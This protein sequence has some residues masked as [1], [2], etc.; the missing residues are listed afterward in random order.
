MS[1][2]RSFSATVISRSNSENS[3]P[4]RTPGHTR[5]G[6]SISNALSGAGHPRRSLGS[7]LGNG[8]I[9]NRGSS[10]G[11]VPFTKHGGKG[12]TTVEKFDSDANKENIAPLRLV[13]LT[14]PS[15]KRRQVKRFYSDSFARSASLST[16]EDES[17]RIHVIKLTSLDVEDSDGK[18]KDSNAKRKMKNT[19]TSLTPTP[20]ATK[21]TTTTLEMNGKVLLRVE[22]SIHDTDSSDS[23]SSESDS[24]SGSEDYDS[25]KSGNLL[26]SNV[27]G[28]AGDSEESLLSA[29]EKGVA[30]AGEKLD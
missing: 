7:V 11:S 17:L 23:E 13:S 19:I 12:S 10:G 16:T 22:R 21:A 30:S 28:V 4:S 25:M 9:A 6:S 15:P 24:D 18:S 14:T 2:R 5:K 29:E 8:N 20:R 1:G 3:A 27:Q 26:Q